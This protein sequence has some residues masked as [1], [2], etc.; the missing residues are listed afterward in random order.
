MKVLILTGRFGMGHVSA[1]QA[2]KEA[3]EEI[4]GTEAVTVDIVH[5]LFPSASALIYKTFN[6]LSGRFSGLYNWINRMDERRNSVSMR[7]RMY[8]RVDAL[9]REEKP[10]AIVS[11]LPVASKYLGAYIKKSGRKIRYITCITDIMPHNEWISE[12][13]SAYMVGDEMTERILREKGVPAESIYVSGI[14]VRRE[15]RTEGVQRASKGKEDKKEKKEVLIMGGGLGL[16]PNPDELINELAGAHITVI[17]GKNEKL[18]EML[19]KNHQEIETVGYTDRVSEYMRRADL[20]ISKAGGVT[21]F[22]AIWSETPLFVLPPF[23][24]QEK[25]NAEFASR[26]GVGV[27][28]EK[29]GKSLALQISELLEDEP[30]RTAMNDNMKRMKEA[31]KHHSIRE[32]VF[33]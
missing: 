30:K 10:D 32:I 14:P 12:E 8:Q 24:E 7:R 22:E 2:V 15:F 17:T 31:Y 3:M 21:V 26:R 11:T 5:Y 27:I 9:M 29:K 16:I 18:R 25:S 28:G 33:G 23:L 4:P 13:S 6:V 1:A 19:Q 20:L